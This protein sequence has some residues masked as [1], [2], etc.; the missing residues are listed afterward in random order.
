[1]H[2]KY[3]GKWSGLFENEHQDCAI[4]ASARAVPDST[5]VGSGL[6]GSPRPITA[7]LKDGHRSALTFGKI[8]WAVI[9]GNLITSL[10]VLV[11][12]MIVRLLFR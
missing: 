11:I 9:L 8:L 10:V 3:C 12:A 7:A 5:I 2:C 4:A 1:M 6:W